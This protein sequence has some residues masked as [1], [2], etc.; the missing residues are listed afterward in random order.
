MTTSGSFAEAR[1]AAVEQARRP[2]DAESRWLSLLADGEAAL[3]DGRVRDARDL[4][5]QTAHE[6]LQRFARSTDEDEKRRLRVL[7]D[8]AN[9]LQ[10][11]ARG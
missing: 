2:L 11:R 3:R 1:A 7:I 8:A 4:A 9:A 6:A 10:R 5:L